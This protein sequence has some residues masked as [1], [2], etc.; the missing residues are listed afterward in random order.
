MSKLRKTIHKAAIENDD[1]FNF[2]NIEVQYIKGQTCL[3]SAKPMSRGLYL[4]VTPVFEQTQ[5]SFLSTRMERFTGFTMLIKPLSRFSQNQLDDCLP[6]LSLLHYAIS[7]VAMNNH[8]SLKTRDSSHDEHIL[9]I[10][11]AFSLST[12]AA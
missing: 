4:V 5:G 7:D 2:L 3:S 11:K 6:D 10:T 8:I 9:K 1:K 12:E